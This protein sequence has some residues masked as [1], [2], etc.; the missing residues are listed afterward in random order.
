MRILI[1][2]WCEN[3]RGNKRFCPL[4]YIQSIGK[5]PEQKH[6]Q[7][8]G[9]KMI[10]QNI[11][12]NLKRQIVCS[13][14]IRLRYMAHISAK[15]LYWEQFSDGW[16]NMG[17]KTASFDTRLDK[18]HRFTTAPLTVV[19]LL[20]N[21]MLPEL[22]LSSCFLHQISL[23]SLEVG[24]LSIPQ[25]GLEI[26]A[27]SDFLEIKVPVSAASAFDSGKGSGGS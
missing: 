3:F 13:I 4:I 5:W 24:S 21:P 6:R 17:T 23:Y 1:F 7:F 18:P 11:W 10:L 22:G 20:T 19:R 9:R 27:S 25:K 15:G 16:H 26:W 8:C 12:H 2:L 14:I